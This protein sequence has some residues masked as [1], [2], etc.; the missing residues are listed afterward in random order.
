MPI[1]QRPYCTHQCLLALRG[2]RSVDPSCPN[3]ADHGTRYL[4]CLIITRV[5]D[6]DWTGGWQRLGSGPLVPHISMD[7]TIFILK[8]HFDSPASLTEK[9]TP[10]YQR[11][12]P[13]APAGLDRSV[14]VFCA[15]TTLLEQQW[16]LAYRGGYR[17]ADTIHRYTR[18]QVAAAKEARRGGLPV[19][20]G[21]AENEDEAD[22]ERSDRVHDIPLQAIWQDPA[23]GEAI[24]R[25]AVTRMPRPDVTALFL[26][27]DVP[28]VYQGTTF[29]TAPLHLLVVDQV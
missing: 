7:M 3:A 18:D 11:M 13:L 23:L 16:Y 8:K 28:R 6:H 10:W 4:K 17:Y 29:T 5:D 24:L 20:V 19:V 12:A 14:V 22:D 25:N 2:G 21:S 27:L 26:P 1:Q 9:F 15:V